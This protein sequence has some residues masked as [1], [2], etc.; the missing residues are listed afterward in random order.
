MK[1]AY[2]VNQYPRTSHSFIRR[3]IL[4]VEAH[5]VEVLRFSLRPLDQ[6]LVSEADREELARTRVVLDVGVVRH[7]LA[8]LDVGVRRPWALGRALALAVRVGSRSDRGLLRHLVYLAEACVLAC[9]LRKEG[10]DHLHAH[11]GTNSATVALLCREVGGPSYSFT[12]HGPE[13]FDRPESLRLGEKI[14]RAAFA[15]AISSFGRAQL[16]RWSR[17]EDWP[18]LHVVRCGLDAD[19]TRTPRSAAPAKPRLV[20]VAR[21]SE[22]KGHML[23]LEAAA[24]LAAEGMPFEI[25]LAGDGPL[26]GQIEQRIKE[27]DLEDRVRVTGWLSAAKVRDEIIA[28]RAMVLPSFAEGLPVVV[29]EALA[30]GRPVITTAIAGIPELVEPGANGWL[31][32]AGSADALAVAMRSAL[33]ALPAELDEMGRAGAARVARDHD[34]AAEARKL[35]ALFRAASG[36]ERDHPRDPST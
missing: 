36:Q 28:S 6:E 3:E 34:A 5:G 11:F 26:R 30:L 22:Q 31:V 7:A 27:S 12:V 17:F 13:E 14:R 10:A 35:V 2:L 15:V 20:C 8:L 32:P 24:K 25:V 16:C 1:V 4:A 23:L 18:K 21:L 9:W 29:M 19:L 33:Q